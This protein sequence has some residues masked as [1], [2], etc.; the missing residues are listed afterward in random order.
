MRYQLLDSLGVLYSSGLLFLA[1]Q[2]VEFSFALSSINSSIYTVFYVVISIHGLHVCFG[3]IILS[4]YAFGQLAILTLNS[5]S[6]DSFIRFI[7]IRYSS[8]IL[9]PEFSTS[10]YL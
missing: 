8:L 6:R 10:L 3:A 1:L 7:G 4:F 5:L 2:L 9:S